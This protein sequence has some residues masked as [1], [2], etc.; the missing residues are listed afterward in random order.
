MKFILICVL[1]TCKENI[2]F[3]HKGIVTQERN[4][5]V[6]SVILLS[7][8]RTLRELFI[9]SLTSWQNQ[10]III[11]PW[12]YWSGS[13]LITKLNKKLCPLNKMK[14]PFLYYRKLYLPKHICDITNLLESYHGLGKNLENPMQVNFIIKL[15]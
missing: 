9:H 3:L 11:T 14:S 13:W 1:Y 10:D 15:T 8:D 4:D 7:H 5:N 2:V 12:F 6:I